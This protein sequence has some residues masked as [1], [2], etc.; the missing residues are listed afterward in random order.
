MGEGVIMEISAT[1]VPA[2]TGDPPTI[3]AANGRL[4][5]HAKDASPK[6][7]TAD[8]AVAIANQAARDAGKQVQFEYDSELDKVLVKVVD[9]VTNEV[10][11]QMPTKEM[12]EISRSIRNMQGLLL[13]IRA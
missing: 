10:I 9:G 5:T 1:G 8:E 6:P 13:R 12:V 7:P 2:H 3:G 4:L 11:H